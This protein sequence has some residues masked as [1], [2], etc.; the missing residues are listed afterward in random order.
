MYDMISRR[1]KLLKIINQKWIEQGICY[2]VVL[3]PFLLLHMKSASNYFP[4]FHPP[5][6]PIDWLGTE[7]G[8]HHT[9][10]SISPKHTIEFVNT[11]LM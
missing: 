6:C 8:V 4:N 9:P 11:E 7:G 5:H 1:R 2:I 3:H 10:T